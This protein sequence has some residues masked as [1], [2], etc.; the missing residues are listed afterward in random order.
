MPFILD[1]HEP[2]FSLNYCLHLLFLFT[3]PHILHLCNSNGTHFKTVFFFFLPSAVRLQVT[4][5]LAAVLLLQE[6]KE[7]FCL[8]SVFPKFSSEAVLEFTP[9]QP[10]LKGL[11]LHP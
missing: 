5:S 9:C 1:I 8:F 2:Y 11:I 7:L 10:A 6:L 3:I 4:L